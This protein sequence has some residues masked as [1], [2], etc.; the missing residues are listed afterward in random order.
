[1]KKA[2]NTITGTDVHWNKI[3]NEDDNAQIKALN[4]TQGKP[5]IVGTVGN[6]SDKYDDRSEIYRTGI[7]PQYLEPWLNILYRWS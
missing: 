1:M 5:R 6:G 7:S 4:E 2:V 3:S